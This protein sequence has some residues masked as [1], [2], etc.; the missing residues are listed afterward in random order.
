MA[1]QH[2][3]A[4]ALELA[5]HVVR[6][7]LGERVQARRRLVDEEEL[8]RP[9]GRG[10]GPFLRTAAC[11][12]CLH[13]SSPPIVHRPHLR[14]AAG[15]DG[16]AQAALHAA[17]EGRD[18]LVCDVG[19]LHEAEALLQ[20]RGGGE[21]ERVSIEQVATTPPLP[22]AA[23]PPALACTW[24]SASAAGT[25]LKLAMRRRCWRAV[26]SSQ[27][28]SSCD[29]G[30]GMTHGYPLLKRSAPSSPGGRCRCGRAAWACRCAPTARR[31]R[32]RRASALCCPRGCR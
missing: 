23:A 9:G 10:R 30:E 29:G 16:E 17:R 5:D 15:R 14:V 18:E 20:W 32:P 6:A 13:S 27:S 8:Q 1:R 2:D 25:P 31:R 3:D 4:A 22:P 28:R 12:R 24:S 19:Q 21:E 26:S 11:E 7:P